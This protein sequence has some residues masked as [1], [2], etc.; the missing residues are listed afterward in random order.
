MAAVVPPADQ[1]SVLLQNLSLDSQTKAKPTE[2]LPD[3][4]KKIPAP[5]T[6]IDLKNVPSGYIPLSERSST[7]FLPDGM[8][9][10]L[11]YP[12]NGYPHAAYYYG[13]YD[14]TGN[15]WDEYS[16]YVH[17]DAGVEMSQGLY[18]D[19][20][21]LVYHP[22]YGFAPYGPFSPAGSAVPA[23]SHDSQIYAHHQYQYPSPYFSVLPS[24]GTYAPTPSQGELPAG[25]AGQSPLTVETPN[26]NTHSA[27]NSGEKG[28][29]GSAPIRPSYQNSSF[30][31][32]N[33]Y[34]R[35]GLP[36]SGYQDPR[37]CFDG[38]RS[39]IPWLDGPIFSDGQPR[40]VTSNSF[41]S[42]SHGNGAQ[43]A[44]NQTLR[45]HANAMGL[46]QPRPFS[47]FGTTHGFMNR[48]YPSKF[49]GQ[50]G[51]GMR[52]GVG[53][54]SSGYDAR[55]GGRGWFAV[56]S[57]Y[58]NRERG[59]GFFSYGNENVD[60]LNELSKGPRAKS[61]KNQMVFAPTSLAVRGRSIVSNGNLD[62]EKSNVNVITD[63]EKY[64]R[65]DF[66]ETYTDAK[67]FIIKSY[68]EDDVHKSIKY[69]V[70]SSTPNGNKKLNAA[71]Q[72]AQEKS[73]GCPVFLFFSVNTSG[74]FVGVAEMV[75][76]VD[77]LKNVEYWQQDKWDGSFP[78]KWHIL[79]DLPN[80]LLK[81]IILENNE[82]KPVTN[83]RDTQEVKLDQGLQMLKIFK[84]HVSK[85]CILE[86][87]GF[88]EGRQKVIQEKKAKQQQFQKQVWE[89]KNLSE[90][91]KDSTNGNQKPN[92]PVDIPDSMKVIALPIQANGVGKLL[93]GG[94]VAKN[95]D[96]P[97]SPKL[98]V[99]EKPVVNGV[100]NGC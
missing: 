62:E 17:Q 87:F 52:T 88:Y 13:G 37:F 50:Y 29:N 77:F 36:N 31:A 39:P 92:K 89:G 25:A 40:P 23:M 3:P 12:Q 95:G 47:A 97:R 75:G 82:N 70:W 6:Q 32:N 94:A 43:A 45:P 99:S 60:G 64:N 42:V 84:E 35:G 67:F 57:K 76:P 15:D 48:M 100:A 83:S 66:P 19:N 54:G 28:T 41:S 93:D 7:P 55:T 59:N 27:P 49:Y 8:D 96:A 10:S 72:E 90:K 14:G 51:N 16:R 24:N 80:S 46:H 56:D 69:S 68:S 65:A 91:N 58:K 44:R 5:S 79:K 98:T 4:A 85:T 74:Q 20:A 63:R 34:G 1:A 18:G 61:S 22:G 26:D 38:I 11:C 86:D 21:S 2:N 81:H 30:A 71:Y 53:Y 33:S 9:P 73:A 78:V